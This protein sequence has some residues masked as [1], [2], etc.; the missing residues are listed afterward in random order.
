MGGTPTQEAAA[1]IAFRVRERER[2]D[3]LITE[4]AQRLVTAHRERGGPD[5]RPITATMVREALTAKGLL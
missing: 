5:S 2:I 4:L 3:A 1:Y